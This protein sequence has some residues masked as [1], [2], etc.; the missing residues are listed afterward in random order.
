MDWREEYQKLAALTQKLAS[1]W[2]KAVSELMKLR[3]ELGAE[4]E[5]VERLDL[6]DRKKIK[7][8]RLTS[9]CEVVAQYATYFTTRHYPAGTLINCDQ[10]GYVNFDSPSYFLRFP[11]NLLESVELDMASVDYDK[12]AKL[13]GWN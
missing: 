13:S 12:V 11:P 3:H 5:R 2:Q 8:M 4:L 7:L 9:D 1:N 10:T 6:Q